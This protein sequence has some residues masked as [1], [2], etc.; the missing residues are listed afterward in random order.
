LLFRL[1]CQFVPETPSPIFRE[2]PPATIC[3]LATI[4][5]V[6]HSLARESVNRAHQFHVTPRRESDLRVV[7]AFVQQQA[8]F[9]SAPSS[10]NDGFPVSLYP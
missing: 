8:I 5:Q 10:V 7:C 6:F 3:I 9:R 2:D 4:A 1:P